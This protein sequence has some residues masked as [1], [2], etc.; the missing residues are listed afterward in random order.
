MKFKLIYD[1]PLRNNHP[2]D[3]RAIRNFLHP[4]L[5]ELWKL[6]RALTGLTFYTVHTVTPTG[7]Q[8]FTSRLEELANKFERWGNSF[9]AAY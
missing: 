6:H 8:I 7:E 4:Q 3:K 9:R 1:G 2:D 5:S